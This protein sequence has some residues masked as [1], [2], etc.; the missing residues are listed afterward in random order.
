MVGLPP[1]WSVSSPNFIMKRRRLH[2]DFAKL[3]WLYLPSLLSEGQAVYSE[4]AKARAERR[5]AKNAPGARNA[6]GAM[7]PD[8]VFANP[9]ETF[10]A[11]GAS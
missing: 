6:H 8:F 2:V 11:S 4:N 7:P 3:P 5:G 9:G 10:G 1:P